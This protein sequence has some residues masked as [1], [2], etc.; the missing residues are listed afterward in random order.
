[1]THRLRILVVDD[2]DA[3]RMLICRFLATL[4]HDSISACNG[5]EAVEECRKKL[6]DLILMDIMMPVMDGHAAS[7]EIRCLCGDQW[8]PIIFLSAKSSEAEQL[9]GLALGDDYL[10]K[11]VNLSMLR[12]RIEVMARIAEM[13]QRI[14]ENAARLAAY[15]DNN[16]Q[17]QAFTRHVLEHIVGY[18]DCRTGPVKRW[19][20]PARHLSGDVIAHAYSPTGTLNVLIADS[21]GHGL[22]AAISAVPAVDTFY[23]MVR[24]GYGIGCIVREINGKL[25]GL[26]PANRFV[27]AA[28]VSIDPY[29]N[30]IAVW[31]GGIPALLFMSSEGR[32]AREWPSAHPPLGILAEDEFNPE[33]DSWHWD[34]QG[35]IFICSDG[36]IEAENALGEAF[37]RTALISTLAASPGDAGFAAAIAAVTAHLDGRDNH[38][39]LSLA[40]IDCTGT[41]FQHGAE[42]GL[43]SIETPQFA[44]SNW[45][46]NLQFGAAEIRNDAIPTLLARWL[47]QIALN[48]EQFGELLL[49]VNE[50][51]NNAVDH[52]VLGLDSALKRQADGYEAFHRARTARLASLENGSIDVRL[53]QIVADGKRRLQLRVTDSGQGFDPQHLCPA[54]AQESTLPFGRGIALVRKLAGSLHYECGGTEAI[55]DYLL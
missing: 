30:R 31:N 55:V 13:Q 17:E 12:A 32:L 52:G 48:A 11:P 49:I 35:Q 39:D 34:D 6:P 3:N 1:M 33:V 36:L 15:R 26:L 27:A 37:G 29:R 19:I 45:S 53:A 22:A 14:A 54:Q 24:R 5:R 10:T 16:E 23:T 41:L 51:C 21:T 18:S 2:I 44:S 25:H 28:L 50:L 7:A 20:K 4:G 46:L 38:D 43:R 8:L 42:T 47:N 9:E 40:S